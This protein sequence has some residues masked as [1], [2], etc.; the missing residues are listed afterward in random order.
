MHLWAL[1]TQCCSCVA[2]LVAGRVVYRFYPA[3]GFRQQ[4]RCWQAGLPA[5][6]AKLPQRRFVAIESKWQPM[7]LAPLT[8]RPKGTRSHPRW[9]AWQ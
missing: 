6:A 4:P 5:L 3:V 7:V 8:L 1:T 9:S 2:A